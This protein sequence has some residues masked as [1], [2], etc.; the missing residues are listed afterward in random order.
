MSVNILSRLL[1]A[2]AKSI[3]HATA[4]STILAIELIQAWRDAA[5]ALSRLLLDNSSHEL[6]NAPIKSQQLFENKINEVAK[7]NYEAQ[8]HRF[9][10]SS[11]RNA[12]IQKQQKSSYLA[13]GPFKK[14]RQPT[15]SNRP[16]QSQMYRSKTHS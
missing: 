3:K 7:S 4:M 15:K 13:T 1:E 12:N 2:V 5:T 8:Q 14:P 11:P 9:L 10:A 6:R 16:K